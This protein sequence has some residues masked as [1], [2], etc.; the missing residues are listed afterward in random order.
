MDRKRE[1]NIRRGRMESGKRERRVVL[2]DVLFL[3]VVFLIGVGFRV[4]RVGCIYGC[5]SP[6]IARIL[7]NLL[8]AFLLEEKESDWKYRP[9]LV[10]QFRILAPINSLWRD[11]NRIEFSSWAGN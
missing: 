11:I 6:R 7:M 8:I 10:N 9:F 4:I 3:R 1:E 5:G 2:S